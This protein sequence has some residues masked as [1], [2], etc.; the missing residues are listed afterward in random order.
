M[1]NMQEASKKSQIKVVSPS[2][3]SERSNKMQ[4]IAPIDILD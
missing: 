2:R 3:E 4:N 1:N